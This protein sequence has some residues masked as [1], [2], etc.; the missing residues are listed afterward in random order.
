MHIKFI[1]FLIFNLVICGFSFS[2]ENKGIINYKKKSIESKILENNTDKPI[3]ENTEVIY[4]E[5]LNS[6]ITEKLMLFSNRIDSFFGENRSDS[7]ING[8]QLRVTPSLKAF[9][10]RS[11]EFELGANLNLKLRNLD[12][13]VAKFNR[14]LKE[15]FEKPKTVSKDL[16][17][18]PVSEDNNWYFST[19]S[20]LAIKSSLYYGVLFR[21]ERNLLYPDF[22]NHHLSVDLGWDSTDH[23]TQVNTLYSDIKIGDSNLFRFVNKILFYLTKDNIVSEHGPSFYQK[24]NIYNSISYNFR[25][26]NEKIENRIEH[27]NS[28]LNIQFRNGTPSKKIYIDIIPELSYPREE[29]YQEVKSIQIKVEYV[30]G[31]I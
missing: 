25:I 24:L 21:G 8:S 16:F 18:L 30:F 31:S 4:P 6:D 10:D 3:I 15:K 11:S 13:K 23:W 26:Q 19:Q 5:E 28:F 7:E 29:A 12:Q 2:Q 1:L 27:K 17:P 9:T 22:L 14:W 20:K